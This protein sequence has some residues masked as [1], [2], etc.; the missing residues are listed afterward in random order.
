MKQWIKFEQIC[1]LFDLVS[2]LQSILYYNNVQLLIF[3]ESAQNV[4]L[5][6]EY[7]SAAV[8]VSV[9]RFKKKILGIG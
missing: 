8:V 4:Y 3:M 2:E 9:F 6:L 5:R 7:K 1:V